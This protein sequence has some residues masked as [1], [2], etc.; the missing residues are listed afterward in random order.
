MQRQTISSIV[1]F[2]EINVFTKR[3]YIIKLTL[4]KLLGKFLN[5]RLILSLLSYFETDKIYI[6]M[7]LNIVQYIIIGVSNKGK[8]IILKLLHQVSSPL[9]GMKADWKKPSFLGR[10]STSFLC[11]CGLVTGCPRPAQYGCYPNTGSQGRCCSW[12]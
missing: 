7:L 10:G 1:S 9:P 8:R 12:G 4:W 5:L 2:E 6:S 3:V 11:S